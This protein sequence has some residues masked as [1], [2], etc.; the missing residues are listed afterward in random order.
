MKEAFSM[1]LER[2]VDAIECSY[3]DYKILGL[4]CQN[5][6]ANVYLRIPNEYSDMEPYFA[7]AKNQN[8]ECTKRVYSSGSY[9]GNS[10]HLLNH[11]Q[12]VEFF[13]KHLLKIVSEAVR[14][15]TE[16]KIEIG[17]LYKWVRKPESNES[18]LREN[19]PLSYYLSLKIRSSCSVRED[20]KRS[21]INKVKQ[22]NVSLEAKSY[23]DKEIREV[24]KPTFC[25]E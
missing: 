24:K 19:F 13:N 5:C 10:Y 1:Y 23:S 16:K 12:K 20:I 15:Q 18:R 7:H 14:E 6:L 17:T 9:G 4:C 25:S 2:S 3:L 11:N 22:K 21:F 8:P